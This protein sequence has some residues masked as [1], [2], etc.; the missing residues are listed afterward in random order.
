MEDAVNSD[1]AEEGA[2]MAEY[3]LLL[4][5]IAVFA[6]LAVNGFGQRVLALFQNVFP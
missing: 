3:G 5:G 1:R 6:T 4:V 2:T